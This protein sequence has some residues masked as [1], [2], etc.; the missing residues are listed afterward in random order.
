M[1][2]YQNKEW[3]YNKYWGEK[4]S[5]VQIGE[6]CGVVKSTIQYWMRKFNIP[7]RSDSEAL[8]IRYNL[9]NAKYH[10]KEWLQRKYLIEK[11]DASQI[12]KLCK[13]TS[14]TIYNWLKKFNI[15]IRSYSESSHLRQRNHCQLSQKAREFI[16]GELLG[17]ANLQSHSPYSAIF[18]YSSKHPEYI[19][20]ISNTLSSFGIEGSK[21]RKQK[22]KKLG[23]VYYSFSSLSYEE[24]LPIYKHWYLNGKKKIPRDLKLTPIVLRQHH[25]GDGSLE[26][27]KPGNGRPRIKLATCGFSIPDVNW[28][29][30]EL[31]KLGFK[32][33]RQPTR[34]IIAISAHSTKDF[35]DYIGDCPVKCYRYKF[36]Y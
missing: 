4:L 1:I 6:L 7:T 31:I 30:Q 17:D 28:L 35:L 26:H 29:V 24:L 9:E 8:I 2:Q 36:S 19:K 20:Y 34:N 16:D 11:S 33:T 21:I 18:A 5:T 12:A 25:I 10:N 15:P 23:N 14:G 27:Q 3:L 22:D 13:V 32:A